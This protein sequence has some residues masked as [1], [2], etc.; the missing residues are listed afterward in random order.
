MRNDRFEIFNRQRDIPHT[1][2]FVTWLEAK[3]WTRS[4]ATTPR[5]DPPGIP[6]DAVTRSMRRDQCLLSSLTTWSAMGA[7]VSQEERRAPKSRRK[8]FGCDSILD[9][10]AVVS[11]RNRRHP[12]CS[13]LEGRQQ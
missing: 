4:P 5:T 12:M 8:H 9:Q 6:R 7:A 3:C 1:H 13:R 11:Q 10:I 2:P